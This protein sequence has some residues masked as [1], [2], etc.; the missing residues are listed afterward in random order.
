MA[1]LP[2]LGFFRPAQAFHEYAVA[3]DHPD[4]SAAGA[5]VLAGGGNAV[6]AAIATALALGVASPA[7]SGFGGGGFATIC[8]ARGECTF[9]DFR[10]TAP[11]A[12]R[13][14]A[15][16]T[17]ESSR[18]GG[19]AVA[20]PGEPAGL[21]WLS[22][23]LGRVGL[24]RAAAPAVRL[25]TSGFA[26]SAYVSTAAGVNRAALATDPWLAGLFLPGGAPV[27]AGAR[28]VRPRLGATLAR[29]GREGLAFVRG[30]FARA[31]A[32]AARARGGVLTEADVRAYEPVVRA[33]LRVPFRG[34]EI[35]TAPPPS[36]GGI[37]V[38]ETLGAYP[39]TAVEAP[40]SSGYF[41]RLAES[42]R[43]AFDDRARYV[44][45]PANPEAVDV[46]R[47][48]DPARLARRAARFDAEHS[49]P[50][51]VDE[52]ARDRGTTH[53]CVVDR[54]GTV[55]SLTTTVNGPFGAS[56]A[57]PSMDVLLN[58]EI[59]DFSLGSGSSYGLGASRPNALAPGRRP[60]SSMSPSVVL[61]G[62]RPVGCV[63][64]AGGPRIATA[65]AQV[66]LNL[67]VHHMDPESAVSAPRVHHQGTPNEL[68]VDADVADDVREGLRRRGHVPITAPL[69]LGV[70]QALWID[71]TGRD[72][73]ILA[74]SD[75]RKGGRPAGR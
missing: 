51:T 27:A 57:I 18:V 3:A 64:A 68:Q 2:A 60:V 66:L 70:A 39:A 10:E 16:R 23:H 7:S 42:F 54:E 56:V 62:G 69:P 24:A 49:A 5:A 38:A 71:G 43:A 74:A 21:A 59:D 1:A 44:G 63:G 37:L 52:P 40:G 29:Y 13:V 22:Q 35:V 45:D 31:A 6:D 65:T 46:A 12:A 8:T 25:A 53:L 34:D 75:P 67:L 48:L 33:P 30:D 32:E 26:A 28:M 55:V 47:L 73:V 36:A 19:L 20:V 58:D 9:V 4:A 50:I 41:H 17:P 14:D 61:R 72:R 11:A 15:Y